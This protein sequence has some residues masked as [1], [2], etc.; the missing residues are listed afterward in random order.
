MLLMLDNMEQLRDGGDFLSEL[1]HYCPRLKVLATSRRRLGL[2]EEWVFDLHGLPLP[3]PSLPA[4]YATNSG[5]MLFVQAARR[6]NSR[7]ILDRADYGEIARICRLLAGMPLG[8][9]MAASWV[10]SFSCQEIAAEIEKNLD[11]LISTQSHVPERHRSMRAIFDQSWELL[12]PETRSIFCQLALFRGGFEKDMSEKV[13]GATLPVLSELL[14]NSLVRRLDNGRFDLH[15]LMRQYAAERLGK[16]E[17]MRR[18]AQARFLASY[19]DLAE[20]AAPQLIGT[21]QLVWLD[22]LESEQDNLRQALTFCLERGETALAARLA[23]AL[24]RFWWLRGNPHEGMR[25]FRQIL[26]LSPEALPGTG[27][28]YAMAG[29]LART[30]QAYDEAQTWLEKGV[31][32]LRQEDDPLALGQVINELGMLA[33]DQ[34]AFG[35]AQDLFTECLQLAEQS[36]HQR[37]IAVSLLNLGMVSHHQK[38][39]PR[40]MN[41]YEASLA[42]ARKLALPAN[43]AMALNSSSLLRMELGQVEQAVEGLKESARLCHELGYRE[44]LAWAFVG[45]ATAAHATD[46][47][48]L[49]A[50]L[51]GASDSLRGSMRTPLPPS[52]QVR[53]DELVASLGRGVGGAHIS[54]ARHVGQAWSL[55]QAL[56][57][58]MQL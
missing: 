17:A 13:A 42:L 57:V 5:V 29:L 58:A 36:G 47:W 1:L 16:D 31:A 19:L 45:L 30:V 54:Q 56:D 27:H 25:W 33:V 26:A 11:F 49:A 18:A 55:S 50:Q 48:E 34:G 10:R 46:R 23:S 39:Y 44:G 12:E 24:G 22:R 41:H 6:A 14:E 8:L 3:E 35:R 4:G 15:E 51:L 32:L 40:A 37:G 9:E 38:D 20:T 53:L 21:D 28:A 2:P 52:N 43:V 7:L